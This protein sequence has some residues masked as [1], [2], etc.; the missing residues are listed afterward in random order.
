MSAKKS[1]RINRWQKGLVGC[2]FATTLSGCVDYLKHSDT[3]TISA[4]DAQAWNKTIH[5]VDPWPPYVMD[6]QIPGDGRRTARVIRR[7][8]NGEQDAGTPAPPDARPN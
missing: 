2:L 7:Y 4:G 6:T 5:T 1:S 3:V 8:T